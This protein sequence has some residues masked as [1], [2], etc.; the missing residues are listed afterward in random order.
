MSGRYTKT[1]PTARGWYWVANEFGVCMGVC[2]CDGEGR[3]GTMT[4]WTMVNHPPRRRCS[5]AVR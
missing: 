4:P 3:Y 5:G 2:P 1:A